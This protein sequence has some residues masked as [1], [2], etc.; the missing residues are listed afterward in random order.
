MLR[1]SPFIQWSDMQI[2]ALPYQFIIMK[3]LE[4]IEKSQIN[5][6]GTLWNFLHLKMTPSNLYLYSKSEV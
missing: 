5:L 4:I 3:T 1:H 2:I 6:K